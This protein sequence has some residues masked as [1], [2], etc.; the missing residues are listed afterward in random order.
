MSRALRSA[1]SAIAVAAACSACIVEST[2]PRGPSNV[3]FDE[4]T[5][6]GYFCGEALT[7]W[8]VANRETGEEAT[9]GCEQPVLFLDLAPDAVYTFDI[10]GYRN[11]ELCWQGSCQVVTAGSGTV[12]PNCSRFITHL[13]GF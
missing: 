11:D 7:S 4:T 2:A 12:Y 9:A 13:C 5:T 8:N 6:L 3:Q 10:R 1:V